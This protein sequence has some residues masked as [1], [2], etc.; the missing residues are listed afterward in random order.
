M[1]RNI[2][3]RVASP[4]DHQ[5]KRITAIVK[6]LG[7]VLPLLINVIIAPLQVIRAVVGDVAT[8]VKAV[9]SPVL[10]TIGETLIG[11]GEFLTSL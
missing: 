3:P 7:V 2:C 8:L 1:S 4:E 11:L 5:I 9:L 6:V 10:E